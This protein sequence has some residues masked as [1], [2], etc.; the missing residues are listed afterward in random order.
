MGDLEPG[1]YLI[2]L[3]DNHVY[4]FNSGLITVVCISSFCILICVD[5]SFTAKLNFVSI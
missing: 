1:N 5:N 3:H 4:V 2:P